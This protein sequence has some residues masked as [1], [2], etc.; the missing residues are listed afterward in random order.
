MIEELEDALVIVERHCPGKYF[1][2]RIDGADSLR[3]G[4]RPTDLRIQF[5]FHSGG[6]IVDKTGLQSDRNEF[7]VNTTN[8]FRIRENHLTGG[9]SEH[10]ATFVIDRAVNENPQHDRLVL[11]ARSFQSV[12]QA[13]L[14]GDMPP[15]DIFLL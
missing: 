10:S 5:P 15:G 6:R 2:G 3:R 1:A 9:T 13:R 8:D 11:L 12:E 7:F 4:F 14:P